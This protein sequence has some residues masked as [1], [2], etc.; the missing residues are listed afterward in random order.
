MS[1]MERYKSFSNHEANTNESFFSSSFANRNNASSGYNAGSQ[2]YCPPQ[3][4]ETNNIEERVSQIASDLMTLK[5]TNA[6]ASAYGSNELRPSQG[7]NAFQSAASFGSNSVSFNLAASGASSGAPLSSIEEAILRSTAPIE[8]NENEEICVLG[9]RGIWANKSEIANWRGV[10]PISEYSINED[11]NPEVIT[12]KSLQQLC[13]V[14]ELAIRYLRPPSPPAPGEIIIQ[15]ENDILTP[16]APPIIIRQQPARP[17]TP[18]PLVI[19]E[20]P[21]VPPAV[22]GCKIIKIAG[23]RLPPPPRKVV[24]ERLAPLPSKPQSVLIERWL[25]YNQVKRR[26]IFQKASERDPVV[27]KPRNVIVQWEAPQCQIKKEYKYLGVIKAN[28]TEYIQ[29]YGSTLKR[30]GDM[31]QFVLDIK[32]PDGLLL[33]AESQTQTF[34]ELEGDVQAMRLVDL[35]KEGLSEYR[36]YLARMGISYTAS[37]SFAASAQ[38]GSASASSAA[39]SYCPPAPSASYCPPAPPASYCPPAPPASYCPPAPPASYCPPSAPVASAPAAQNSST[40][41]KSAS[42]AYLN[43][44]SSGFGSSRLINNSSAVASGVGQSSSM[45]SFG[46]SVIPTNASY[47]TAGASQYIGSSSFGALSSMPA[48][49]SAAPN[50]S[51]G[52][53]RPPSRSEPA[54]F[55]SNQA[56]GSSW[57]GG[58]NSFSQQPFGSS[59]SSFGS[60][61]S[62]PNA[63]FTPNSSHFASNNGSSPYNADNNAN[64]TYGNPSVG[65]TAVSSIFN[66]V[67]RDSNGKIS[68]EEAEKLLLRLNSRLGRNYGENDVRAF[69]QVL[70]INQDGLIDFQE[71]K[72]AFIKY[73]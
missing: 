24:I 65:S 55:A 16:P 50:A 47:N 39:G 23:R 27:V 42:S 72:K 67:D 14:Q 44:S 40:Y 12:K 60:A 59:A 11:P 18:E 26:V 73:F 70:D 49:A 29:R 2:Q 15:Q 33:A 58:S 25:P 45:G 53:A 57:R 46:A 13:Y 8:I 5:N 71:F 21:P 20:C 35:D 68:V 66:Q 62:P 31:P 64:I 41:I 51:F 61:Y 19:R 54:A 4:Y 48:S 6:Q 34:Y 1:Y 17:G 63:S 37:S 32:T 56:Y 28:P 7:S 9:Q 3:S 22:I 69:F 36:E 43:N 30:L 38:Y 52:S 10:V